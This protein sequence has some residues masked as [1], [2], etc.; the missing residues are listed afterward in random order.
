M[1]PHLIHFFLLST[2]K[3]SALE[4]ANKMHEKNVQQ[5][6]AALQREQAGSNGAVAGGPSAGATSGPD[7]VAV[8]KK[9]AELEAEHRRELQSV[10]QGYRDAVAKLEA[11]AKKLR[12]QLKVADEE[13]NRLKSQSPKKPR[14]NTSL[15]DSPLKLQPPQAQHATGASAPSTPLP[16]SKARG[17]AARRMPSTPLAPLNTS[18]ASPSHG[19]TPL[20]PRLPRPETFDR[21]LSQLTRA[22]LEEE[23]TWMRACLLRARELQPVAVPVP[24]DYQHGNGEPY[25]LTPKLPI[26]RHTPESQAKV[27]A[28]LEQRGCAPTASNWHMLACLYLRCVE[29]ESE[30]HVHRDASTA[31]QA[32]EH[33][34]AESKKMYTQEIEQ[35]QHLLRRANARCGERGGSE[36]R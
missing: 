26:Y 27:L 3:V 20:L 4:A 2:K 8:R 32:L 33:H 1:Q 14:F 23:N 21:A 16:A 11:E 34:T 6:T 36:K 9:V 22:Q 29:L 12:R 10:E 31:L 25:L 30:L 18:S 24:R 19:H 5:L 7:V 15:K 13:R 28:Y 17:A 35:L